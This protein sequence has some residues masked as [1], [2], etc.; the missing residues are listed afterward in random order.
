MTKSSSE[1]LD[2]LSIS[3]SIEKVAKSS[4]ENPKS[5]TFYIENQWY[6]LSL[7]ETSTLKGIINNLDVSILQDLILTPILNV[8]DPRTDEKLDFIGGIKGLDE[9]E[10]KAKEFNGVAFCL[11]PTQLH[12]LFD[13]ADSGMVMP[14]KSTWFEPKL[15]SGLFISQF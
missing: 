7:K 4:P 11:Y 12:E 10:K 6:L 14:P 1:I 3:F 5:F 8:G 2:K 13:I 9:L 15:R